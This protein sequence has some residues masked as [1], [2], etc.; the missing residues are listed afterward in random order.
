MSTAE[1][2]TTLCHTTPDSISFLFVLFRLTVIRHMNSTDTFI[3]TYLIAIMFYKVI[4]VT[5]FKFHKNV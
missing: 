3:H 5:V 4:P 1:A 2:I